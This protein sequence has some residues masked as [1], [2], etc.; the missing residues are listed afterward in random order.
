[1]AWELNTPMNVIFWSALPTS[2][3]IIQRYMGPYQLSHWLRK[4][5]YSCQ[6]IDFLQAGP[7]YKFRTSTVLDITEQ[8]ITD[9]TLMIGVSSTFMLDRTLPS[10]IIEAIAVIREKYPKIKFV[11]GGN[12]AEIYPPEIT[13]L[14]DCVVVGLAEDILLDLVTFY[15]TGTN[16]PKGFRELPHKVKFYREAINKKFDI[17]TCDHKW[18]DND[19]VQ[20][21]ETLPIEISR[22]CIF[23]CKFCQYPLLGRS[24]FDYT[25]SMDLIYDEMMD[26]YRRFGTTNYTLLDD[27]FNDTPEKVKAFYEMTQRLPFKIRFVCYLRADLLDRYPDEV[28]QLKDAGLSGAHFGI[29]SLHPEASKAVGKAWSGKRAKEFLPWL[30]HEAWNDDVAL[31]ITML[32]GIGEEPIESIYESAQWMRDNKMTSWSFKPLGIVPNDGRAFMSEFGREAE[33]YG[34]THPNPNDI[35]YW[36]HSLNDWNWYKAIRVS[37]DITQNIGMTPD[38]PD[39]RYNCWAHMS[40]MTY[41]FTHETLLKTHR[42]SLDKTKLRKQRNKW[43]KQYLNSVRALT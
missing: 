2:D 32:V 25:R 28:W 23:K 27:T 12:K 16:E 21:G 18:H 34:Y 39:A 17:Q 14:F 11:L 19:C 4:H 1:M 8:F 6:V 33:K 36:E 41:G 7:I 40:L 35:Y 24:K 30:M 43:L 10:N 9:E 20:P 29:E 37:E 13:S 15:K 42:H 5:D 22:G 31:R 3:L 26:N 38:N